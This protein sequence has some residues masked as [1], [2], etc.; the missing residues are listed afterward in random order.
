MKQECSVV[1]KA[2]VSGGVETLNDQ[3]TE[4]WKFQIFLR[5]PH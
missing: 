4:I 5:S 2:F 3:G 1:H